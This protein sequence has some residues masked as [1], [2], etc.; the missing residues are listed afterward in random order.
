VKSRCLSARL[1][2]PKD[3]LATGVDIK[4][5]HVDDSKENCLLTRPSRSMS[6]AANLGLERLLLLVVASARKGVL[7]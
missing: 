5:D 3:N 4:R 2:L 7:I 6:D 1:P